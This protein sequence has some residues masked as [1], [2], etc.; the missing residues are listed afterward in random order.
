MDNRSRA[1]F[2]T[3]PMPVGGGRGRFGTGGLS[4]HP[5]RIL[6]V[7][8]ALILLVVIF[9]IAILTVDGDGSGDKKDKVAGTASASATASSSKSTK[10]AAGED[11]AATTTPA[12]VGARPGSIPATVHAGSW[13]VMYKGTSYQSE[14]IVQI[15]TGTR[16][17]VNCHAQGSVAYYAGSSSRTWAQID[18]EDK[19]GFVPAVFLDTGGDP[20][21]QV[22]ACDS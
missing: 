5:V 8:G 9:F 1:E 12:T 6:M 11:D 3:T 16:V 10:P 14:K 13:L 17:R 21:E 22:R 2:H 15:K 19:T 18:V 7:V 4:R 20:A